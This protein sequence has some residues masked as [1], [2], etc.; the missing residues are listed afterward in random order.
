[1]VR[2]RKEADGVVEKGIDA[3][4]LPIARLFGEKVRLA[5]ESV[6]VQRELHLRA[7]AFVQGVQ[8]F[9]SP[10][11]VVN[12]DTR[13]PITYGNVHFVDIHCCTDGITKTDANL[14]HEAGYIFSDFSSQRPQAGG[15]N[16]VFSVNLR[17]FDRFAGRDFVG[18]SEVGPDNS[19]EVEQFLARTGEALD[20][21]ADVSGLNGEGI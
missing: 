4:Q 16:C 10:E 18:A 9:L 11:S 8:G 20:K 15:S 7:M 21:A 2:E 6:T 13:S 14:L 3:K 17:D 1:M 19:V 5:K 12:L